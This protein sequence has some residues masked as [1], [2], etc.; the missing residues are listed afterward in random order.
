MRSR[1]RS[2]C[3][4]VHTYSKEFHTVLLRVFSV[5]LGSYW[6]RSAVSGT[7]SC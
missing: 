1:S 7:V 5:L 6:A 3:V 2:V 4:C